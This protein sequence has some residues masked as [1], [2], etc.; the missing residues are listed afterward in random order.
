[1][2]NIEGG[3]PDGFTKDGSAYHGYWAQ[4]IYSINEH[5]G[6]SSGLS[7]LSAALHKRGMVGRSELRGILTSQ[8]LMVDIVVNHMAYWCGKAQEGSC[9]PAGT[10]DY[11][12]F[13]PFNKSSYYHDFCEIDYNNATSILDVRRAMRGALCYQL[14][15]CSAGRAQRMYRLST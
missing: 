8:Y 4:D 5:F 2:T 15:A 13:N 1:V 6:G 10:I 7:D 12:S 11:S 9:G 3:T 14:T